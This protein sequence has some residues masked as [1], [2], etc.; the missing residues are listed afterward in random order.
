MIYFG[1]IIAVLL[2][3]VGLAAMKWPGLISFYSLMAPQERENV[4]M[5]AAGKSSAVT[6]AVTGLACAVLYYV[7]YFMG[8]PALALALC[9]VAVMAGI[10]VLTAVLRKYDHNPQRKKANV[11]VVVVAAVTVAVCIMLWSWSRPVRVTVTE[12][13]VEIS[14]PY[15]LTVNR[16][17]IRSVQL[18]DTLPE[19]EVRTNGIGMGNIQKGH[20][21]IEGFGACRLY[22]DLK[23]PPFVLLGLDTG[24]IV[25]FNTD[26][27]A[28]T[29]SLYRVCL[30]G[31]DGR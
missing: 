6:M 21:R 9:I 24:D 12:S 16:G 30:D 25:I 4:D 1:L 2:V 20:F 19:I 13:E 29:E 27:P 18:L 28:E 5:K 23:Y 11:H 22:V 17:S 14:G 7:P 31:R 10:L 8:H 15:G 3:A 26:D